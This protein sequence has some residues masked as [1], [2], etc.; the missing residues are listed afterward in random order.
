MLIIEVEMEVPR[1]RRGNPLVSVLIG[2][3]GK[4]IQWIRQESDG[5]EINIPKG[6]EQGGILA[7]Q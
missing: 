4:N 2:T 1:D 6:N 7:L 3:K 5:V